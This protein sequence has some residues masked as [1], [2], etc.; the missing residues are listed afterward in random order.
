MILPNYIAG[1][2]QII[3]REIQAATFGEQIGIRIAGG[4]NVA[5]DA[6]IRSLV[7]WGRRWVF[8]VDAINGIANSAMPSLNSQASQ[9]VEQ[10]GPSGALEVAAEQKAATEA[11]IAAWMQAGYKADEIRSVLLPAYLSQMKDVNKTLTSQAGGVSAV[12]SEFDS[13]KSKGAGDHRPVDHA[14]RGPQ[15]GRLSAA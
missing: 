3:Q 14:R 1:L 8:A 13:L 2:D 10:M 15:S 12:A 9:Y 6:P 7:R 4:L 5:I 11:Q